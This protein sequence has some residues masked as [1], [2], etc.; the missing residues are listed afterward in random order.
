MSRIKRHP[1][2]SVIAAVALIVMI[3]VVA[4]AAYLASATGSLPWQTDPT[5]IPVT[6]FTG[7]PRLHPA[8]SSPHRHQSPVEPRCPYHS[9]ETR[10][11]SLPNV[12]HRPG[13]SY[14]AEK[15]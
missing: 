11:R 1:F 5:R 7:H 15:R 13:L 2:A 3:G 4:F 8:N 9:Q 14:G 6:P 12:R 10:F